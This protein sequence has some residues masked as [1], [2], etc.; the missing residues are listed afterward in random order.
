MGGFHK[1]IWRVTDDFELSTVF[2]SEFESY[3]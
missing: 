2:T 3:G 1:M